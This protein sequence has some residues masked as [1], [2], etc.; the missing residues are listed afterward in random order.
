MAEPIVLELLFLLMLRWFWITIAL[1]V[2]GDE[3]DQRD[4]AHPTS[5]S[6]LALDLNEREVQCALQATNLLRI[7]IAGQS[8]WESQEEAV[9][10]LV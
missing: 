3:V 9:R 10:N 4:C 1:P 6:R 5:D 8:S 7:A 2:R